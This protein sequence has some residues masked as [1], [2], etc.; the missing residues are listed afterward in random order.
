M[1]PLAP[2]RL[3]EWVGY[4]TECPRAREREVVHGALCTTI[5]PILAIVLLILIANRG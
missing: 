5:H 1:P 3:E 4:R 2:H